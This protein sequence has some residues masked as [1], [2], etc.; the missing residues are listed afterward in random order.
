MPKISQLPSAGPLQGNE[1][2]AI[3]Q[4]SVTVNVALGVVTTFTI[5]ALLA[6]GHIPPSLLP[7]FTGEVTSPGGSAV[8]TINKSISPTWLALHSFGSKSIVTPTAAMAQFV[9]AATGNGEITV[10]THGNTPIYAT[11]YYNGVPTAPTPP[12]TGNFIGQ[13]TMRGWDGNA[14]LPAVRYRAYVPSNWTTTSN[15][16]AAF[17]ETTPAGSVSPGVAMGVF[18]DAGVRIGQPILDP[19]P[20]TLSVSARL[21]VGLSDDGTSFSPPGTC[22]QFVSGNGLN[23]V[24][25]MD[26]YGGMPSL[27]MRRGNGLITSSTPPLNNDILGQISVAGFVTPGASNGGGRL[28]FEAS[29][30]WSPTSTP[31]RAHIDLCPPGSINEVQVA[32]FGFDPATGAGT[33]T[34]GAPSAPSVPPLPSTVVHFT[35]VAGQNTLSLLE[36][37]GGTSSAQLRRINGT[38]AAPTPIVNGDV[39]G[40]TNI[41]GFDGS[42]ISPGIRYLGMAQGDWSPTS[43]PAV[44]VIEA[45]A[46]GSTTP[47]GFM[48]VYGS[49]GATLGYPLPTLGPG[50]DPGT[51]NMKIAGGVLLGNA[52]GGFMGPGTINATA[53]YVNGVKIA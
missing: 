18:G 8:L 10:E 7:A 30:D 26:S 11:Q 40:Q 13:L 1:E 37:F 32:L 36:A 6:G 45:T 2:F 28:R 42:G 16:C 41:V 44:A 15:E 17:I 38:P 3:V 46:A 34:V 23:S 5:N 52:T 39:I 48:S 21:F 22:G 49:G 4:N 24:V 29:A 19:G 12:V 9:S 50:G 14:F 33:L 53:L 43:H 47:T 35:G 31:A 25:V 27:S 20:G 51:G